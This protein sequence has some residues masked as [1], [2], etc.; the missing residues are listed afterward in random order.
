[1]PRLSSRLRDCVAS[2]VNSAKTWSSCTRVI[3]KVHCSW[4][5]DVKVT[6]PSSQSSRSH[7]TREIALTTSQS[8][9]PFPHTTYFPNQL[10]VRQPYTLISIRRKPLRSDPSNIISAACQAF[11]MGSPKSRARRSETGSTEVNRL[12]GHRHNYDDRYMYL[13]SRSGSE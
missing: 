13:D 10:N 7:R 11:S 2:G 6:M 8:T 1:M 9:A 5:S 4:I 12:R 3:F